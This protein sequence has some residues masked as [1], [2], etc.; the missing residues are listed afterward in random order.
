MAGQPQA[1]D[2]PDGLGPEES[3]DQQNPS[4]T[5][6]ADAQALEDQQAAG[7]AQ[8][9]P[10][11]YLILQRQYTQ[12]RQRWAALR[13][14][15]G[16]DKTATPDEILE[17]VDTLRTS[18]PADADP[19]KPYD[20]RVAE[21]EARAESAHWQLQSAM[22]PETADAAREFADLARRTRDPDELVPA[23]YQILMRFAVDESQSA[24]GAAEP[25]AP[26][27]EPVDVDFGA[28]G[29]MAPAASPS[30]DAALQRLRGSGNVA[31]GLKHIPGLSRVLGIG[32]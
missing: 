1:N 10:D 5:P 7:Q 24:G 26:G 12:D 14:G 22:F 20:P 23:F 25:A 31:Q 6:D 28:G 11:G 29:G 21:L 8:R 2:A 19:D 15:L 17:A 4:E 13:D 16:L 32:D 3:D 27:D 9:G 18:R 30:D